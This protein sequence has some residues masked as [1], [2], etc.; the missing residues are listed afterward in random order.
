MRSMA[1]SLGVLI[2][3]AIL[4]SGCLGLVLQREIMEDIREPP[5][6]ILREQSIGFD[7]TFT[8]TGLDSTDYYNESSIQRDSSVQ[9]MSISFRA[10][11]PLSETFESL[12]GNETNLIR[13]VDAK[14]WSP[15]SKSAGSEPYWEIRVTQDHSLERWD[16]T[17]MNFQEG[18]WVLEV[19]AR[20]YGWEPGIEQLTAKDHFDVFVTITKPCI[21]FAEIHDSDDCVFQSELD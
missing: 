2:S 6:T 3:V 7:H 11:M 14:L 18:I 5:E 12:I 4:S 13:Y 1:T 21:R 9:S 19:D 15:G 17:G 8:S 20:G 16:Y 10:Q